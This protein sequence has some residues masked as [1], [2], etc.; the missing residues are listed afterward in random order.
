MAKRLFSCSSNELDEI[1]YFAELMEANNIDCYD[2]P[3]SSFGLSKP[4]LW[5][6]N[7]EDYPRAKQLFHEHEAK[8]A[9][10]AQ[11]KYQAETGYNP[12]ASSKEQWHFF[13][14]N[15]YRKR[16][17]LPLV[18]LGFVILYWY[19]ESIFGLFSPG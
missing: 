19:F 8:Y 11:K 7:D 6:K 3:G 1:F 13:L 10:Y 16:A 2:V 15:L 14:K 5:I 17:I 18:F 4:S 12:N 9:E